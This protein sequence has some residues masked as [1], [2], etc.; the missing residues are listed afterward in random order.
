[1]ECGR[2]LITYVGKAY[3]SDQSPIKTHPAST[4]STHFINK[5]SKLSR[6]RTSYDW[7]SM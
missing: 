5:M 6:S 3:V 1:M 4:K 2:L 7:A